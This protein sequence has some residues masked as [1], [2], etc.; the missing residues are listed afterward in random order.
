M[1]VFTV[2]DKHNINIYNPFHGVHL[3]ATAFKCIS[4]NNLAKLLKSSF[5]VYASVSLKQSFFENEIPPWHATFP[6]VASSVES[7]SIN[8]NPV[9]H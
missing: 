8:G 3:H 6:T 9:A 7:S 5:S 4:C 1:I 2:R